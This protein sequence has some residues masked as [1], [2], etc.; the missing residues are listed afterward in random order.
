MAETTGVVVTGA[1]GFIGRH[2]MAAI[3]TT[4]PDRPILALGGPDSRTMTPIDLTVPDQL[5]AA[6]DGFAFDTVVHLA[7]Q[8]SVTDAAA[9][10]GDV[11]RSNVVGTINL[12]EAVNALSPGAQ[13]IHAGSAEAYGESFLSG[14]PLDE[15]APLRPANA[16]ARTKVAAELALIDILAPTASVVL[17][18]LFNHTGPGQDERFVAPSFAAQIARIEATGLA[19]AIRVGDLT[20]RR[21]F[22]NVADAA[23]AFVA[24]MNAAPRLERVSRFNVCSGVTRP[25]SDVLDV[26]LALSNHPIAVETDPA[27]M[28]PSSIGMAAGSNAALTAATGWAPRVSFDQTMTELM[29]YW[30][31]HA[32]R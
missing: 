26:L 12:A 30:R 27:R 13:V 3:K 7:A 8:S 14:Q 17:L 32:G 25:V 6:L 23:A 11:W 4:W 15:D 29:T 1:S 18:R 5:R 28:R 2:V 9:S 21:D 22:G 10:P 19:G 31:G 20:A 16:Y 24:V